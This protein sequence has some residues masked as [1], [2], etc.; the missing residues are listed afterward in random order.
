M[1]IRI[2]QVTKEYN[3]KSKNGKE[4][5]FTRTHQMALLQCSACGHEF[6]RRTRDMDHRRL[7][8]DHEHVCSNCNP[9]KYAQRVGAM[10]RKFWN[11]RV[12][13]GRS[14]DSI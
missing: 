14:I 2:F 5:T 9:K 7:T 13:D 10:S 12:N 11:I 1:L 4:H 6:E 3:R 8:E